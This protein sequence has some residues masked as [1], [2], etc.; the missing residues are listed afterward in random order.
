VKKEEGRE[1][2][3]YRRYGNISKKNH[4]PTYSFICG[5]PWIL[6]QTRILYER[7]N[8]FFFLAPFSKSTYILPT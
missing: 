4:H 8:S 7:K 6:V 5:Y 1:R 3:A 2:E